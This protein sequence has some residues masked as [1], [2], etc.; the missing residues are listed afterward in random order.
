MLSSLSRTAPP[1]WNGLLSKAPDE[2]LTTGEKSAEAE[3]RWDAEHDFAPVSGE[4]R[5]HLSLHY[6]ADHGWNAVRI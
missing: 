4:S 5:G 3:R 1:V 2:P 6:P